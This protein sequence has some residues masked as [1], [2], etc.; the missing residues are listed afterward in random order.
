MDG[1]PAGAGPSG[2]R[3]R[4]DK[5]LWFARVVKSR[6]LAQKLVLAGK[7]RI[8]REKCGSPS[9]L[10]R[11]GDVLTIT[12]ERR[13]LVLRI[14]QPG[15]RRGPPVEARQL[16]EDLSPPLETAVPAPFRRPTGRDRRRR[17]AFL[18]PSGSDD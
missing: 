10:V 12:V 5:W 3:Q 17:D 8:N 13:V 9:D 11:P 4:I 18:N 16:Y 1:E 2:S 14:A 15:V 6:T 7:V